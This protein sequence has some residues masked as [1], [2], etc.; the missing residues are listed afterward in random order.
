LDIV[1]EWKE[2]LIKPKVSLPAL[3][4]KANLK[5]GLIHLTIAVIVSGVL[6]ALSVSLFGGP[7]AAVF[8]FGTLIIGIIS[9]FILL[10]IGNG[11][12]WI[13]ANL[14]GGKGEFGKQ[15][16]LAAAP[17]APIVIIQS[18]LNFI[19]IVGQLLSFLLGIYYLYPLTMALKTNYGLSTFKAVL[20]W[21]IPGVIVFVVV[22]A[23]VVIL[24]A[25]LLGGALGGYGAYSMYQ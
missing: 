9:M 17:Y 16:H 11:V 23:A 21:L 8:G 15:V 12:L 20:A 3:K 7:L 13:F 24:G 4:K 22:I 2:T 5:D 14:L 1:K 25:T 18:I 10:L 19:P 6:G